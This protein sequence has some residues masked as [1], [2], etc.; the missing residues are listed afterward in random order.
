[1]ALLFYSLDDDPTAWRTELES[2]L[3]SLDFRV[4]P[5]IGD[6]RAID[7]ALVWRP[8]AG[9]LRE[10]PNL[11][12]VLSLAAGVDALLADPSLPDVPL[13]RLIDP[14]LTRTMSEF[15]LLQVLKYHRRLDV[16]KAQQQVAQWRLELPRPPGGTG[17]GVMGLGELGSD[18]ARTL[19]AH[20]FKVAGWSRR[21]KELP[22]IDCHAGAEGLGPFL[23]AADVLVCLLPLTAATRGIL[24][25][26]L[27]ARLPR[28]ARLINVGRGSHLVEVD[29]LAALAE[30]AVGHASLDVFADEPLP[31]GHPFWHHPRIDV[32]PHAAS[33][34]LPESA[35]DAVADN[36]RRLRQGLPF[37]HVV[38]RAQGY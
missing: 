17:V 16:F 30:G 13:C 26:D 38:D 19:A 36:L 11:R 22:G 31:E 7:S 18:A 8:P 1:M 29:L 12:V 21:A 35:A 4:W 14:S 20:G 33:Y 15:V 32:T 23:A 2:R 37:A 27:F 28:G 5:E 34:G 24:R 3:P 6:A 25:R 10:L 9:M